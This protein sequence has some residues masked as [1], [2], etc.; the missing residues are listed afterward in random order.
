[1][2]KT[3]QWL[4]ALAEAFNANLTTGRLRI[5][6]QM[7]EPKLREA[8]LNLLFRKIVYRCRYFPSIAEIVDLVE[9]RIDPRE[10]AAM[11]VGKIKTAVN[12]HGNRGGALEFMGQE[13]ASFLRDTMG[14]STYDLA[15]GHVD[16][17]NP[18]TFAQW[19]EQAEYLFR[20]V[21]RESENLMLSGAEAT[22]TLGE[23]N[24][25][26]KERTGNPLTLGQQLGDAASQTHRN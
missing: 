1:M 23:I 18:A 9:T 2:S 14:V 24:E 19:R 10:K 25:K 12:K 15:N 11:L 22:K 17:N 6:C 16:L 21:E 26:L 13:A 8:D 20:D 3:E 7:L 4:T 5:Y